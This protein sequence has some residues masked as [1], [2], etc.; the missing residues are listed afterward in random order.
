MNNRSWARWLVL[1]AV[2]GC[3][4]ACTTV[5]GTTPVLPPRTPTVGLRVVPSKPSTPVAV[6]AVE[7]PTRARTTPLAGIYQMGRLTVEFPSGAVHP[8]VTPIFRE[9]QERT[10]PSPLPPFTSYLGAF[11]GQPENLEFTR[12]ITITFPLSTFREANSFLS[13]YEFDP[14]VSEFKDLTLIAK[15]TGDGLRSQA[16]LGHMGIYVALDGLTGQA[17]ANRFIKLIKAG[18]T[19]AVAAAEVVAYVRGLG[20]QVGA[21]VGPAHQ[22]AG[23]GILIEYSEDRNG[24]EDFKFAGQ[25]T[26]HV[27]ITHVMQLE[28]VEAGGRAQERFLSISV[29]LYLQP[30]VK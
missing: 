9:L 4:F 26:D 22:I 14:A 25:H 10:L 15:V 16:R 17:L 3:L 20:V 1:A 30:V 18:K 19:P 6:V 13:V 27:K 12:P 29:A 11:S 28:N 2:A 7:N 8:G 5:T 24:F 21:L 23:Y